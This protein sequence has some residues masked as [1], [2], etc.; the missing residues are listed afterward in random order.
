MFIEL[1]LVVLPVFVAAV[2][3]GAL[4]AGWGVGVAI[5][6]TRRL[7]RHEVAI[8]TALLHATPPL[9]LSAALVAVALWWRQPSRVQRIWK[10]SAA[11]A[12]ASSRARRKLQAIY[13]AAARQRDTTTLLALAGAPGM[14]AGVLELLAADADV[15]VRATTANNSAAPIELM[16]RLALDPALDV[17]RA[18]ALNSAVAPEILGEFAAA[19][20][21]AELR[22]LARQRLAELPSP[23][24]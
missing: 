17:R 22:E 11:A 14:P 4:A 6:E 24:T 16:Q 5:I 1:S 19:A 3:V 2:A 21:E 9:L 10:L 20:P 8:G 23:V 7:L 13:L 15:S 12:A 18:L